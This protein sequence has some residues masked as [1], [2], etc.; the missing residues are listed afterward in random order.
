MYAYDEFSVL[1]WEGTVM[2]GEGASFPLGQMTTDFLNLDVKVLQEIHRRARDFVKD[3]RALFRKKNS[4]AV[5]P[6]QEKLN[7]AWDVIFDLPFYRSLPLNIYG[8]RN[9]LPA[10][11]QDKA[12]WDELMK[13]GSERN[14]SFM[15]FI[16]KLEYFA[17]SIENFRGQIANMLE[18]YFEK[19][20]RRNSEAYAV[21]YAKYYRDMIGGGALLVPGTPFG[22]EFDVK[23]K[24]VP[25]PHPTEKGKPILAEEM[26][27][28]YLSFF[29]Y[30][31][32]YRGLIAGNAP[33][34][35]HNCGRYF[36]L[37]KGYDTCYCNN[38]APGETE[39]TCRKVGAHKKEARKEGKTPARLEYDK[40]YNRLK[41]RRAR[42]KI[43]VDEWNAAVALALEYKDKAEAGKIT[44]TELRELYDKM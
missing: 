18:L 13:D 25:L 23:V 26:E 9:L 44:D 40:I 36:L 42:G 17:Q 16:D 20:P 33:R 30:T 19:L 22:Q 28:S 5:L 38:I 12:L 7:A 15:V 39:K 14:K 6:A 32:F 8:S 27:F 10:L 41:T 34:R 1:F 3:A 24:F 2:L 35:C 43:S 37:N 4:G 21:A 29:L 31:D 11:L